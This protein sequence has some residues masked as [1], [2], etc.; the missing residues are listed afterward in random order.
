MLWRTLREVERRKEGQRGK[1][2]S[3]M[4]I[5]VR[6]DFSKKV[7]FEQRSTEQEQTTHMARERVS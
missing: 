1:V 2:Y 3:F 4:Y 7:T 5:V 6:E